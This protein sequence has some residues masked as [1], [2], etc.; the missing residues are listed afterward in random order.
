MFLSLSI[1]TGNG[2]VNTTASPDTEKTKSMSNF[3]RNAK[4]IL[5]KK[6]DNRNISKFYYENIKKHKRLI[7]KR[8]NKVFL[9]TISFPKKNST[10]N[11][12]SLIHKKDI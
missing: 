8:T 5:T 1:P 11:T 4:C 10:A 6:I 2:E 12:L 9:I 7:F 3:Y